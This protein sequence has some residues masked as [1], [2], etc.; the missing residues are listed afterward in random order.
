MT[1]EIKC[2]IKPADKVAMKQIKGKTGAELWQ[3]H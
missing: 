2:A 1:D 3:K